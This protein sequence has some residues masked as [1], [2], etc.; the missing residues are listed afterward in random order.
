[1][2]GAE[3]RR[4]RRRAGL[5]QEALAERV[6]VEQ[7]TVSRWERDIER[8]CPRSANALRNLLLVDL[9]RSVA[10]R[11]IALIRNN[12]VTG[13]MIDCGLRLK[14]INDRA[15]R[16]Y[17]KRENYDVRNDLGISLEQQMLDRD[18]VAGWKV[19]QASGLL[20]GKALLVRMFHSAEDLSHLTHY[21]PLY[22]DGEFAGVVAYIVRSV[23]VPV[24]PSAPRLRYADALHLDDLAKMVVLHRGAGWKKVK[25]L[26]ENDTLP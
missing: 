24:E 20:K 16:F 18:A 23:A 11:Q 14:E 17:L 19:L 25:D 21:E 3:I 15:L 8:P 6:G 4:L 7:G 9:E 2:D 10:L 13:G 1:M 12:L 26:L 22:E 5:T